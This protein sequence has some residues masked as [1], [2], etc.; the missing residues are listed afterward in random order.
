MLLSENKVSE[1][2]LSRI[3]KKMPITDGV[4]CK[5]K[6]NGEDVNFTVDT[7][8][9]V[10]VLSER[11]YNRISVGK[12]PKLKKTLI[13]SGADGT[14]IKEFGSA[15]F[16]L[17]IG[18]L[19]FSKEIIVADIADEVLLGMDILQGSEGDPADILLSEGV[20]RLKGE[21]IPCTQ[22]GVPGPIRRVFAADHYLIPGYSEGIIDVFIERSEVD[23]GLSTLEYL[24]RPTENF[25]EKYLL[26]MPLVL[27]D[28]SASPT[29]KVRVLNPSD[30]E[31]SINQDVLVGYAELN[32][33]DVKV[34]FEQEDENEV[35]NFNSIRRIKA[36]SVDSSSL[37]N[38][39]SLESKCLGSMTADYGNQTSKGFDL[40]PEHL[41][42]L[43]SDTADALSDSEK[44]KVRSLLNHFSDVFSK[45]ELDIG[46]THLVEH[47]VDTGVAAPVRLPPRPVPLAYAEA[48]KNAIDEMLNQ[49]IIR[50]SSSPWASPI[51]LV[52]RKNSEKMRLCIDYRRVN[53]LSKGIDAYPLPRVRDCL[54][55]VAGA[56][57]FSTFDITAAYHQ[58]PV[59]KSHVE[60][61]AFV[62]KYGL[63]EWITMPFGLNSASQTF[64]RCMEIALSGLQWQTCLIYLDDVIVYAP[65]FDL[66]LS[67]VEEVLSRIRQA[68]LKLKPEKCHLLQ[69]EV[70]FL[71]HVIS[72]HGVLPDPMNVLKIL[73]WPTPSNVKQVRQFL[74]MTS[75]YRRHIKDFAKIAKPLVDLTKKGVEFLWTDACQQS[76]VKFKEILTGPE[77]MAFPIP[78]KE[79]T[80][81]V[82]ASNFA[83][84]GI[85]SQI[86]EG[87][88]KV[89]AYA[90]RTLN[91]AERNYC[92]TEK[93]L[94]A[95]RYFM[96]YFRQYTLGHRTKVRTDHNALVWLFSFKEPKSRIARWIEILSSYEF[97][98]EYR[99]GKNHANCDA[100]S[101]CENPRDCQC[102]DV[103]MSEP[104]KCGPCAKCKRRSQEMSNSWL[105]PGDEKSP[106]GNKT[107]EERTTGA[108]DDTVRMVKTRAAD[109]L[110]CAE[111]VPSSVP[112]QDLTSSEQK[113]VSGS[114]CNLQGSNEITW[115]PW[116]NDSEKKKVI[117]AQKADENISYIYQAKLADKRPDHKD[118][119]TK[120]PEIRHYWNIWESLEINEGLLIKRFYK[121]DGSGSYHQLLVPK[122]LRC[123][124]MRQMHNTL[125]SGHLGRKK[126]KERISQRFY[127]YE[128]REDIHNWVL[129][130]DT[131]SSNK[132]PS[133]TPR[134]ALGSLPVGAPLDRMATDI[135]GPLP[136]TPRGNRYILVV[137]DHFS[138]WVEIFP[139]PDQTAETTARVILNEIISRFGTPL[140]I[141]SDQ[142]RNYESCIFQE[143][144]HL[145]EVKKT[146]TSSRNPKCNGQAERFNK[147]LV[148]MIKAYLKGQE[149][150]WDLYL[151]C[152][153]AA[154]RS[155]PQEST[156]LTPNL[157]MLGREV[158]LPSEIV[159]GNRGI[160]RDEI[161]S[162]GQYVDQLRSNMLTAHR[163]AR[164]NLE[165]S[166]KRRKALYDAKLVHHN[167]Q[168]GDFVWVLNETRKV[169]QCPKLQPMY[170]GPYPILKRLD[171]LTFL[172][173]MDSQG[174]RRVVNHNKL[175]LYEGENPPKWGIKFLKKKDKGK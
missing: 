11:M 42:R 8:A 3:G 5:G 37:S 6:L 74:G 19:N 31:V 33:S 48:E 78:G 158:R 29:V 76:F 23:E 66:H 51:C 82:D 131:C 85:I 21:I 161:T 144:C 36:L 170:V 17:Q 130:C 9:T 49:G 34:L 72:E 80:L 10:T 133:K 38:S 35:Q 58:I 123:E 52:K 73:D 102:S 116:S 71:G 164:D 45:D 125:L 141:H 174:K 67:R 99:Q 87:K 93:E 1:I 171:D 60:K 117:K 101:R 41:T 69:R 96:E 100:M 135:L 172:V 75:Y 155:T 84:G 94:L 7:G 110:V 44:A 121:R 129:K 169:G 149:T 160:K 165:K 156:G 118:M 20:M 70:T 154:Y 50:K 61:T 79:F 150:D 43:Y 97:E 162:Y 77:I 119:A 95:L 143:L 18:N 53:A 104:L 112:P 81:D 24:V 124:V 91:R 114:A 25:N 16:T 39:D 146:R 148:R 159:F 108:R 153:A 163:I 88:E 173:Q 166:A 137:T 168:Q 22:V 147:T 56:K 28:A 111:L 142:G 152:L 140:S 59:K 63:Y 32:D 4:Y 92:V 139:V 157:I 120:S 27:V 54:D 109:K 90:S 145:L 13:I 55:A 65:N 122:M 68:G 136:I 26:T 175:K 86:Q 83:I 14:P 167:Y 57:L 46:R 98:I 105:V 15:V 62:T 151:G 138:K 40:V 113:L 64:Q 89:I 12:R 128:M 115:L 30:K 47:E 127:W 132:A 107:D 103:D 134:A 126:T 2:L 106:Q